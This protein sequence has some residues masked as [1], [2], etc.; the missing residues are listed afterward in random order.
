MCLRPRTGRPPTRWNATLVDTLM[1]FAHEKDWD[2]S[3]GLA[4]VAY[5]SSVHAT[6][7]YVPL[8]LS[9]T[10]EPSPSVRSRQSSLFPRGRDKKRQ[11]RQALMSRAARLCVSARETTHLRLERYKYLNEYHV[12][13]RHADL[14]VG[15]S[16]FV[17]TFML[18][19][20]RSPKLSAPVSGPYPVVGSMART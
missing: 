12:R 1:H 18:E 13:H 16:V 6:T 14:Q 20:S 4:G 11:Y 9:T 17:K 15:E 3:L 8:E 5:N 19:S 7:D 2:I 10:R